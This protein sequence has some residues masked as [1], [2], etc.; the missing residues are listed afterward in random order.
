M[1]NT[2]I[3]SSL[4]YFSNT[5]VGSQ[6]ETLAKGGKITHWM[7]TPCC[8]A[9][10]D[11]VRTGRRQRG[12]PA[13]HRL[14]ASLAVKGV[15]MV[16][17]GSPEAQFDSCDDLLTLAT[18]FLRDASENYQAPSMSG[19][20]APIAP[21]SWGQS[22]RGDYGS[23]A[24]STQIRHIIAFVCASADRERAVGAAFALLGI[25]GPVETLPPASSSAPV[26]SGSM[27]PEARLV[28]SLCAAGAVRVHPRQEDLQKFVSSVAGMDGELV[29][30]QLVAQV[31]PRL[32]RNYLTD[33]YRCPGF[34]VSV[35]SM[36]FNFTVSNALLRQAAKRQQHQCHRANMFGL[37]FCQ[38]N[39]NWYQAALRALFA[40]EA[41]IEKGS[42]DSC[43][44]LVAWI[45]QD[46]DPIRRACS[47][48]Q[49]AVCPQQFALS[50]AERSKKVSASTT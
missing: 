13:G 20:P 8:G 33:S 34:T 18:P 23:Q 12:L 41:V 26:D 5:L 48:P 30:R 4:A 17:D 37:S 2:R 16:A 36:C 47:S 7:I 27:T 39:S 15:C 35:A 25:L 31:S 28:S 50:V 19:P 45:E 46:P 3:L 43:Q 10:L 21:N 14:Q 44:A 22:T 32:D 40:I 9:G 1:A 24:T 6:K 49:V 38:W 29:A 42:G 11:G